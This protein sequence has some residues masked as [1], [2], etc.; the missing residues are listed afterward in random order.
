MASEKLSIL[1]PMFNEEAHAAANIRETDEYFQ[2]LGIDYE[3][4]VVDDG[5]KDLT[6]PTAATMQREHISILRMPQNEGKGQALKEAFRHC[7]GNLVL[8]LDGDLDIHPRQF[9]VLFEIMAA[10]DADV[11]IGAKR[12]PDSKLSYPASRRILSAGYFFMVKVLFGLPLRDTQ[13]GIKLFRRN[14]LSKVF[15]RVLIKK[16]A[17][18]LELLVLAHHYGYRISEGPVV[19]DFRGK[20]GRINLMTIFRMWWDT[21]AVLYRLRILHYY[22]RVRTD[23]AAGQY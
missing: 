23:R 11:V 12:H 21:L 6:Y 9:D 4:I 17:F 3:I 22:D 1:M 8:F 15:H 14:V 18:D 7:T 5:S 16:Y 13:T 20:F 19:V 2:R 10:E